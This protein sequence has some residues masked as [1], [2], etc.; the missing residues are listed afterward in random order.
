MTSAPRLR[1]T[2]VLCI[3]TLAP[4]STAFLTACEV[5]DVDD[6]GVGQFSSPLS[7]RHDFVVRAPDAGVFLPDVPGALLRY[8]YCAL[9]G[10]RS[11][12]VAPELLSDRCFARR[13]SRDGGITHPAIIGWGFGN[14]WTPVD[15]CAYGCL[16]VDPRDPCAAS[17][18][19]QSVHVEAPSATFSQ[20]YS[21]STFAY[22]ALG[23][24]QS[25]GRL[26]S[27]PSCTYSRHPTTGAWTFTAEKARCDW[28][29][30][31]TG[32][33]CEDE[34][35]TEVIEFE[36]ATRLLQHTT[37]RRPDWELCALTQV[38]Q[39]SHLGEC[40]VENIGGGEW[41]FSYRDARCVFE[42]TN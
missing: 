11:I 25:A 1:R 35:V 41:T 28:N 6:A 13:E 33:A 37:F 18:E 8:P 40:L 22:C 9:R 15:E 38:T 31:L 5:D 4:L 27:Y 26:G 14:A 39:S 10:G 23:F 42:C 2:L 32:F 3:S 36:D 21:A 20:Q 24:V 30:M 7:A 12:P 29:C 34:L 16:Q 17:I 19:V